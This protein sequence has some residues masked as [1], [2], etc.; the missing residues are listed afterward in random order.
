MRHKA[1]HSRPH[2][3]YGP[4]ESSVREPKDRSAFL[5]GIGNTIRE[6]Y[7]EEPPPTRSGWKGRVLLI[8]LHYQNAQI[9]STGTPIAPSL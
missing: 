4:A 6:P 5:A 2:R 8:D 3:L 1:N 9:A 7:D